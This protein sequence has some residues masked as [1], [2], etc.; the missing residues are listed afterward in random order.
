MARA[1]TKKPRAKKGVPDGL[2]P[3]NGAGSSP[4]AVQEPPSDEL[5]PPTRP[6]ETAE[7]QQ[8][9]REPSRAGAG[10]GKDRIATSL[11]IAKLQAMSMNDL[12]QMARDLA[13][14]N[15]GTMRKHEVIF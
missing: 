14:E 8:E 13:V 11:N 5:Q 9:E 3:E 10:A 4:V 2:P 15:F 6:V 12:N 7:A 1:S